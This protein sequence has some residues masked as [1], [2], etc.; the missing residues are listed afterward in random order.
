VTLP[1]DAVLPRYGGGSIADLLP[2]A[3]GAL[4]VPGEDDLLGLP[5][6][7]SLCVLLV[8][9]LGRNL[10]RDH[11]SQAPFLSSLRQPGRE[12]TSGIPSTTATSLAS[13]GT[14]LVPGRHG[15][16]GYTTKLPGTDRLLNALRWDEHVD[17][18]DY[19]PHPTVLERGAQAG[20]H[21]TVVGQ[22][23]FRSSGLTRAGLRGGSFVGAD[24]LG[25]RVAAVA[26]AA[27]AGRRNLV[28][29][30]DGDL[31]LTGHRHG[32][33]SGAWR[34]QLAMVD[35]FA[36]ELDDALPPGTV[37]V[38]TGDHGMVDVP[39]DGRL[40]VDDVPALREGVL[41][42]GGE[43]RLRHVYVH[44]GAAED[45][46]SAWRSTLG[47]RASVVGREE[48]VEAGWFGAVEA[49]VAERLG[50]VVVACHGDLAVE[51]RSV[52]PVEATLIGLHGSLSEDEMIVP[53]LVA[54]T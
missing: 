42:V 4:G 14:G 8:D 11:P 31:D 7:R 3:L 6:C 2:S 33:A 5:A 13:L 38:V 19:Q 50:D 23:R 52:F 46:L 21:V 22:R 36:E 10:L 54:E 47:P 18:Y 17:P 53:L 25:E 34:H 9:G 24:T 51:V 20:V 35:R 48:A 28:Y 32:C 30:Y 12:L 44:G 39:V 16:V 37:F 49:R 40:D 29:A 45:V 41:V 15:L 27:S 1:P 26:G 43:A